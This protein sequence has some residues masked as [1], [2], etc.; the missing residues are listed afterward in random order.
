M[1]A[2]LPVPAADDSRAHPRQP[3]YFAA[4]IAFD[5]RHLALRCLVRNLS[6]EGASLVLPGEYALPREF[7]VQ[8]TSL[9]RTYRARL[10]WARGTRCGVKFLDQGR[11]RP[12]SPAKGLA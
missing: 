7:D 4:R 12:G 11:S 1:H 3:T 2:P 8:I 9:R 10:V 6:P 5:N